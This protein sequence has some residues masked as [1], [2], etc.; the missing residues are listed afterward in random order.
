MSNVKTFDR[1]DDLK[2]AVARLREMAARPKDEAVRDSVIKRFELSFELAWKTMKDYNEDKGLS[3]A[4]PKDTIRAAGA[5]NLI[6]SVEDWLFFLGQRNAAAHLYDENTAEEIYD[7][8]IKTYLP[9][10]EKLLEKLTA[11]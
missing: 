5:N 11:V 4:N 1:V 3:F 9:A 6:D 2:K 10:A 7:S 8:V